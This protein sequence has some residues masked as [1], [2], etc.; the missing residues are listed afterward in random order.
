M[1]R[2]ALLEEECIYRMHGFCGYPDTGDSGGEFALKID[3]CVFH[4]GCEVASGTPHH[5]DDAQVGA[6]M[7]AHDRVVVGFLEYR[8][9][10][11]SHR[12]DS[13]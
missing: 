9:Y 11:P 6:I 4:E 1:A 2:S 7:L 3:V 5:L 8:R 12:Q 13:P 10:S